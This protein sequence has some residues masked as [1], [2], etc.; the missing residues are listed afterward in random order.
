[1]CLCVCA[2]SLARL[3]SEIIDKLL[4]FQVDQ[5]WAPLCKFLNV[6]IP[7]VPFPRTNDTA[8]V[9]NKLWLVNVVMFGW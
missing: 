7:D 9:K 4:V 6:P 8:S 5:G 1:M 2:R 3:S